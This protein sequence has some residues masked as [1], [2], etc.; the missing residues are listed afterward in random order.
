MK[1]WCANSK[2]IRPYN[3]EVDD[4]LSITI[5]G[6]FYR[7]DGVF[8]AYFDTWQEGHQFMMDRIQYEI[9]TARAE[10]LKAVNRLLD[11]TKLK[12]PT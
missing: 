6:Q 8:N 9:D 5:Q 3:Q 4:G 12:E 10:Y 11:A 1:K 7:P 2:G